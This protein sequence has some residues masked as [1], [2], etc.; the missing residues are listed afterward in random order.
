MEPVSLALGI[1][2]VIGASI[3]AYKAT[4]SKLKTFCHYSREVKRLRQRF[5]LQRVVFLNEAELLL[6]DTLRD[7]ALAKSMVDGEGQSRWGDSDL[8]AGVREH[9]GRSWE[10]FKDVMEE[11]ET[12]MMEFQDGLNCFKQLEAERQEVRRALSNLTDYDGTTHNNRAR[13]SRMPSRDSGKESK[14]H[15]AKTD[16]TT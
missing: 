6:S 4:V 8:E 13:A 16:S 7:H 9:M 14:S 10:S 2:P 11:I 15:S 12:T 5:D 1:L 3:G